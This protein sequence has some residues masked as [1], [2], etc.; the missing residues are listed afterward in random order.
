MLSFEVTNSNVNCLLR[1]LK[2][3]MKS[4][5]YFGFSWSS[6]T[7]PP[8]KG[9]FQNTKEL[10]STQTLY[11]A[12]IDGSRDEVDIPCGWKI[13]LRLTEHTTITF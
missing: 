4:E 5:T 6:L 1:R 2:H 12:K 3:D 9:Y 7:Q 10:Q 8:D 13:E 11:P